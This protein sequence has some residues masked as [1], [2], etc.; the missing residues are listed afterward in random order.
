MV[1]GP[2]SISSTS[3]S[4]ELVEATKVVFKELGYVIDTDKGHI[5]KVEFCTF[6]VISSSFTIKNFIELD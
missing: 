6:T 3:A 4:S 2:L 5:F 1:Q